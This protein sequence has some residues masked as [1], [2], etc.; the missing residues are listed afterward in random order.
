LKTKQ[1]IE[2]CLP[3][4]FVRKRGTMPLFEWWV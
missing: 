1:S 3:F 4:G 2:K